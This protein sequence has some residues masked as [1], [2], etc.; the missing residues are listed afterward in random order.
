[1]E[2]KKHMQMALHKGRQDILCI[3]QQYSAPIR[4]LSTLQRSWSYF[5]H[6][7][8]FGINNCVEN[9]GAQLATRK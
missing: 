9:P 2:Q 8:C 5:Q 6:T 4:C 3:M 1:M 7:H